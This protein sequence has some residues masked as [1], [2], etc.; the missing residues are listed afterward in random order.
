VPGGHCISIR[1]GHRYNTVCY[2]ALAATRQGE[3]TAK[4]EDKERTRLRQ[5]AQVPW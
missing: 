4:L 2:T 5:Q 1:A 3:D